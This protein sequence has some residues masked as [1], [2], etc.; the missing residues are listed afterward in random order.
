MTECVKIYSYHW[1]WEISACILCSLCSAYS[2]SVIWCMNIYGSYILI[3][4]GVL[5]QNTFFP[6]IQSSL[7]LISWPLL[8]SF[9]IFMVHNMFHSSIML[10]WLSI[11]FLSSVVSLFI[12]F[13]S[14]HCF[15]ICLWCLVSMTLW[16]PDIF[17]F[18][19]E[20]CFLPAWIHY[21]YF[22]LSF[23][24]LAFSPSLSLSCSIFCR[25]VILHLF[26]VFMFKLKI[27]LRNSIY[28]VMK[29]SLPFH[30]VS[31]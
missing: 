23:F 21:L 4:D 25:V 16:A 28:S 12:S 2:D 18:F 22:L 29:S 20:E 17:L 15:I 14:F 19:S 13:L 30:S 7:I 24:S 11:C 1:F 6:W 26:I 9:I 5:Y 8:S 27:S 10:L 3:V 31:L